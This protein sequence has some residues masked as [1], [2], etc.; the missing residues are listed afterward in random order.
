MQPWNTL[1]EVA[2]V[3]AGTAR[4]PVVD[5]L[6]TRVFA[7]AGAPCEISLTTDVPDQAGIAVF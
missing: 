7:L 5:T 6:T 2:V 3:C 4:P 1:H